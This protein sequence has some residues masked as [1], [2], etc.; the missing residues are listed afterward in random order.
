L[1]P[2]ATALAS[3]DGRRPPEESLISVG[4]LVS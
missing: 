2:R 4:T 3:T 1:R